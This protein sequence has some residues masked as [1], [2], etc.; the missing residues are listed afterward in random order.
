MNPNQITGKAKI[1]VD[2]QTYKTLDGA[3]IT[4]GG[5]SREAVKGDEVHGFKESVILQ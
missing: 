3:T 1:R 5:V 2:G 4:P